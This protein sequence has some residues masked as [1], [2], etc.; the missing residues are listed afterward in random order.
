MYI[1]I[2]LYAHTSK[3]LFWTILYEFEGNRMC[4]CR[5]PTH[6]PLKRCFVSLCMS[7]KVIEFARGACACYMTDKN[8]CYDRQPSYM[9]A[10]MVMSAVM[11][12]ET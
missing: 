4:A 1:Y 10:V 5:A 11:S 7:A 6:A 3:T 12:C 8:M 2:Y 9:T